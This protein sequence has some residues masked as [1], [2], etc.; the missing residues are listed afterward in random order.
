MGIYSFFEEKWYSALEGI[1]KFVPVLGLTDKIDEKI[2]S[3]NLFII[4]IILV[5]L[6]SVSL[7]LPK[8]NQTNEEVLFVEVITDPDTN[9]PKILIQTNISGKPT[10][11]K[12]TAI[13]NEGGIYRGITDDNGLQILDF[14]NFDNDN[15][16][17]ITFSVVDP[18]NP[19][20]LIKK[21]IFIQKQ[22]PSGP[23][24]SDPDDTPVIYGDTNDY[25]YGCL[26]FSSNIPV[27]RSPLGEDLYIEDGKIMS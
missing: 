16:N 12:W 24:D 22:I 6:V 9:I 18:N 14:N 20:K 1:N 26:S 10:S 2:P 23:N 15:G 4:C 5:A 7:F 21:I 13:T 27:N 3:M 8:G 19:K 25:S 17:E 11:L